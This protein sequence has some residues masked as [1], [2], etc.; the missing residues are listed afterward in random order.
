MLLADFGADV[1]KVEEH[2]A[3]DQMRSYTPL[4]RTMSANFATLNRNKRSITLNLKS[5]EGK[6]VFRNLVKTSDVVVEGFRPG[7]MQR[8]GLDYES[9]REIRPGL[10]YCSITGYGQTGPYRDRSGHDLN[11]LS[12]A[13][14]LDLSGDPEGPPAA[15]YVLFGD[16]AG[17]AYPAALAI[18]MSLRHRDRTG[19]GEYID[20]SM[21]DGVVS[22]MYAPI[23]ELFL[24]GRS[25]KRGVELPTGGSPRYGI[26]R[27][28]DGRYLSLCPLEDKFWLILFRH[29]GLDTPDDSTPEACDA[30]K[31]LLAG[32][33]ETRTLDQWMED[34]ATVDIC[35]APVQTIA[36]AM[37]NPQIES[38]EMVRKFEH[39]TQGPQHLLRNP[40]RTGRGEE[41]AIRKGAPELGEDTEAVLRELGYDEH[42]MR[43]FRARGI[44]G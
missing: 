30:A 21:L 33:F 20:I 10:V 15:P 18:M 22:T 7:V 39:P 37:S 11:Y 32:I 14:A 24:T 25:W 42:T 1:I 23:G 34:L 5:P 36:E 43:E 41:A 12:Y 35:V 16:I 28:S 3:G 17:G 19:A 40:I 44:S 26:Y 31:K 9:L 8:L 38:R 27:T 4:Y 6:E 2:G 29:L 13:G